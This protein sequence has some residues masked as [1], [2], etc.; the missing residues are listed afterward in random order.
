MN[1]VALPAVHP[2]L[3][4]LACWLVDLRGWI[5]VGVFTDGL[6]QS[7]ALCVIVYYMDTGGGGDFGENERQT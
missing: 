7:A 2:V 1:F 3:F 5:R 4:P 6:R